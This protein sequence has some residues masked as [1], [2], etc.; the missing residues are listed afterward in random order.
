MERDS[1]DRKTVS[2][3][4]DRSY[5]VNELKQAIL[6]KETVVDDECFDSVFD[7]NK[8]MSK[9]KG[10]GLLD[11]AAVK[12]NSLI[13]QQIQEANNSPKP[14][15]VIKGLSGKSI[16]KMVLLTSQTD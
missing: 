14:F 11:M 7:P 3:V 16:A 15:E 12:V 2:K 5:G 9:S 4:I 10:N 8:T 1:N 6:K 13:T